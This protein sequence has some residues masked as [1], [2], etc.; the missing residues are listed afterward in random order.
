MTEFPITHVPADLADRE[1]YEGMIIPLY[2]LYRQAAA[3][4]DTAIIGKTFR[5]CRIDG[6]SVLLA[7]GGNAF[8]GC[9][10][11]D[12]GGDVGSLL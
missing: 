2:M 12:I 8:D 1:I 10:F 7:L 9:H 3:K 5:H 4:G 11:G 6:P